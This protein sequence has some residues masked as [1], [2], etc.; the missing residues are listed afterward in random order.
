[1][2]L[3]EARVKRMLETET[4][5]RYEASVRE[6]APGSTTTI[7]FDFESIGED[8]AAWSALGGSPQSDPYNRALGPA[9]WAI[10]QIA[11]DDLGR[12]ALAAGL[13]QIRVVHSSGIEKAQ[14]QFLEGVLT[15]TV[16]LAQEAPPDTEAIQRMLEEKL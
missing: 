12:D 3:I 14:A 13:R 8:R 6:C 5:P 16:D 9:I 2:G 1:M 4:I 15:L 7:T 11:R 10:E